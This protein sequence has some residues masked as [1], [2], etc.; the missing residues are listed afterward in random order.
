MSTQNARIGRVYDGRG[1]DGRAVAADAPRSSRELV[2]SAPTK[3]KTRYASGKMP[4]EVTPDALA[5]AVKAARAGSPA[6][7]FSALEYF[8]RLDDVIPGAVTSLIEAVL[9]SDD[10][11]QPL[12]DSDEAVA[13]A[14]DLR[15]V[16]SH[17]DLIELLREGLEARYYGFRAVAP[18][19]ETV[20][21]DTG[22]TVQAPT[23]Y[24]LLP[25]H[26]VYADKAARTDEHTTLFVGD[27]PYFEYPEGAVLLFGDRKLTSFED[28]DFTRYGV[29]LACARF[30]VYSYFNHEDWAGYN[31]VFGQPTIVGTL[32]Q[33]WTDRDKEL[34]SQAVFGVS[35]DARALITDKAKIDALSTSG[36]GPAVFDRADEVWRKARSRII[37]SEALTD[38]SGETGT[39]GLGVTLNGI[40]L[41]VARG[42][43]R[44]LARLLTRRIV[45]PYC[46]LNGGR[47]LV[48]VQLPVKEVQ[49]LVA[50]IT[51]DR[52]LQEMGVPQAT[53]DFYARYG[54]RA[55]EEGETLLTP[56][57][58][59][60]DPA[61]LFGGA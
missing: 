10:L 52:G 24:E 41:D 1:H 3:P 8:Y 37:K 31:E 6:R 21:L 27:R 38:G 33:G 19:W 23:T 60:F 50:E 17:L 61:S 59:A 51:I 25:R 5:A 12:D 15:E 2:R 48:K 58:G 39:Y 30:A 35:N 47:V 18:T 44:R 54:R 9:Q 42:M 4:N 56:A 11:V 45:A 34:L 36:G 53:A 46:A 49:N 57:R 40:R 7:L 29:G 43:A 16:F 13:Q 28:V 26:W 55:P 22:R 14:A 20:R 32:L